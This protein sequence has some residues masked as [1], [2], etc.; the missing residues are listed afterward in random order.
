MCD[1]PRNTDDVNASVASH[2]ML[3]LA[4]ETETSKLRNSAQFLKRAFA[5][6]HEEI[7]REKTPIV[8]RRAQSMGKNTG[9]TVGK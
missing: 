3:R 1:L 5:G 6:L 7:A 9:L 4:L 2:T 8:I